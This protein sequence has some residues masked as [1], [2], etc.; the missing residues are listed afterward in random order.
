MNSYKTKTKPQKHQEETMKVDPVSI[1]TDG[2]VCDLLMKSIGRPKNLI[3]CRAINLW[4]NRY[5]I[6]VYTKHMVDD[7]ESKKISYSC[8]AK[9]NNN[10]L[11][12]VSQTEPIKPKF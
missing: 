4:D 8:F 1:E 11:T 2:L 12:I 9:V 10:E 3:M 5:R 6:N 7:I